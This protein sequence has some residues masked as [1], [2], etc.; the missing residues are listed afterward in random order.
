MTEVKLSDSDLRERGLFRIHDV[1]VPAS[2]FNRLEDKL[3]TIFGNLENG[4]YGTADLIKE[5]GK[6]VND[7]YSIVR[8]ANQANVPIIIP[9]FTDSILGLQTWTLNQTRDIKI[10]IFKD[11]ELMVNVHFDLKAEGKKSGAL[12]LGGGVPKNFI[13]Q[14]AQTADRPL[15]YMIQIVTDRPE[16][17]GLSGATPDEA[18]SWGKIHDTSKTCT[19][20]SDMSIALPILVSAVI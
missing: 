2:D 19:I 8:V 7:E 15:D 11:L 12:F 18:I 14:G 10:D 16:L 9:A 4:V 3:T 17:G 6:S 13:L 20:N 5:I 1:C